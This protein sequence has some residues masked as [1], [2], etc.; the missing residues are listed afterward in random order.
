MFIRLF[1]AACCASPEPGL[2]PIASTEPKTAAK[3][4]VKKYQTITFIPIFPN[5]FVGT[6]AAPSIKDKNITG[7]TIIFN[8]A[9]KT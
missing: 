6:E 2:N 5:S 4:E 8:I 7:I 3:S 9:T 1:Q